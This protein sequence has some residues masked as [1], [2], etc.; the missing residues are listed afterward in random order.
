M[1]TLSIEYDTL[2]CGDTSHSFVLSAAQ[3][4]VTQNFT[5]ESQVVV[6]VGDAK[7][8]QVAT[9]D[10][11]VNDDG[12]L[13]ASSANLAG[14]PAGQYSVELWQTTDTGVVVYPS[15]GQA[16]ITLMPSIN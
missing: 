15:N 6:K 14:L 13:I 11:L 9:L 2:K 5:D 3:D 1:N 12:T 7:L 10:T 8:K 16:I 4:G